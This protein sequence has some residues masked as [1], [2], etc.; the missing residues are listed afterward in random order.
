MKTMPGTVLDA[1]EP[2][3]AS[4]SLPAGDAPPWVSADSPRALDAGFL[5][6]VDQ[7]IVS[8]TNFAT[9]LIIAR[10]CSQE[11]LGVYYLAWTVV[12]FASAVQ[13]NLVSVPYT[14]YSPRRRGDQLSSYTGST[15][16]HQLAVS[17][18]TVLCLLVVTVIL[19]LGAAPAMLRLVGWVLLGAMPFLLLREYARR[20]AFA[21]LCPGR[22]VAID[23]TVA[24][25]QLGTLLVLGS[26]G[27][28]SVPTAYAAVGG[29]C[30]VASAGWFFSNRRPIRLVAKRIAADWRENWA[31]GK[32]ALACQL[33]GLGFYLL[34][35]IL[36]LAHGKAATGV[37]AAAISLVGLARVFLFGLS[38]LLTPKAAHAFTAEGVSGLSRVLR[39]TAMIFAGSLGSFCLV[40]LLAGNFLALAVYGADY[41]ASGPVIGLLALATCIDAL[42]ITAANGLWAM[43]RP[44]ANFAVDLVQWAVTMGAAACLVVP[45]GALG[46]AMAMVVGQTVGTSVR[47]LTLWRWM[48][49]CRGEPG[50]A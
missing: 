10:L 5:S 8:A 41:A 39:K 46:I 24:V 12:V 6:I 1:L 38:N 13:N 20:F 35:W 43:D 28:L 26:L 7:A 2:C 3:E 19:S 48:E 22:A 37:L 25:V 21:H 9:M 27:A 18:V 17:L 47:W 45:L 30:A 31:F 23:A 16:V 36:T 4:G 32:W 40:A 33:A 42:G 14:M 44:S 34:P 15:L 11:D 49:S 50:Q 29:A